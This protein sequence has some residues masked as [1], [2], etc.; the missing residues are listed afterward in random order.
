MFI[1]LD[2]HAS[3]HC[4]WVWCQIFSLRLCGKK[5]SLR[6]LIKSYAIIAVIVYGLSKRSVNCCYVRKCLL[7]CSK[8]V[9][10]FSSSLFLT[11]IKYEIIIDN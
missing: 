9:F 11:Y 10:H 7:P 8:L 5:V 2:E 1:V 3:F 6:K 4:R